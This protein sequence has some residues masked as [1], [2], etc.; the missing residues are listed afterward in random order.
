ALLS[1]WLL[2]IEAFTEKSRKLGKESACHEAL[3][4]LE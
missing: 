2:S 3:L 1:T 4:P